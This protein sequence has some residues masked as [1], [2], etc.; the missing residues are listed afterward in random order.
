LFHSNKD[1]ERSEDLKE[2]TEMIGEF[3]YGLVQTEGDILPTILRVALGIVIFPHGAQ[4]LLGWF[5]GD[6]Y[7]ATMDYYTKGMGI[8]ALFVILLIIVEFFGS[9]ALILGLVTRV[10]ALGIAVEML[11]AV[12]MVH[13]HNGFFMNWEGEKEGEGFEFHILVGAIAV[14]LVIGGGGA[15]SV[16]LALS[17]S[18]F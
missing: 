16:D 13:R 18:L 12:W 10:V 1:E 6:G 3:V 7:R 9:L 2:D 8:P 15:L 17:G 5:G 4:K 14:A 11:V